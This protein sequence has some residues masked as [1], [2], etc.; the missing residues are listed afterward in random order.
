MPEFSFVVDWCPKLFFMFSFAA[1]VNLLSSANSCAPPPSPGRF[2]PGFFLS[3][4]TVRTVS[5]I[6]CT[7]SSFYKMKNAFL[8]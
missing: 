8:K 5:V 7:Y 4:K 6:C 2:T 1:P 3:V